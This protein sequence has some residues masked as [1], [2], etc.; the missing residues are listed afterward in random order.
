MKNLF[1][2]GSIAVVT[3]LFCSCS[4]S[5]DDLLIDEKIKNESPV[6]A[7]GVSEAAAEPLES[8]TAIYPLINEPYLVKLGDENT[9]LIYGGEYAVFYVTVTPEI[10]VQE[11]ETAQLTISQEPSGQEMGTY[12]LISYKDAD[13]Y[14]IN[15]PEDLLGIPYMFAIVNLHDLDAYPRSLFTLSSL[16]ATNQLNARAYLYNAFMYLPNE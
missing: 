2:L 14:G 7:R 4:K 13:Q 5:A 11:M 16:I 12:N 3:I 10:M 6:S 8:G 15:T 1:H 9:S